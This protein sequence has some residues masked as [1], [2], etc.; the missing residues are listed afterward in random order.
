MTFQHPR[1]AIFIRIFSLKRNCRGAFCGRYVRGQRC[2]S[3]DFLLQVPGYH[4]FKF[5]FS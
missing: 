4:V 5:L 2:P 1:V 3:P